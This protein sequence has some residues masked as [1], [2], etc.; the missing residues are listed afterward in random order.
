[1]IKN[2]TLIILVLS[3]LISNAQKKDKV[4]LTIENEPIYSSEFLRIYNKNKDIVSAENKKNITEYLELFINYKLK[5]REARDLKLD[6][7]PSYLKEF[8]KY[9]EQ[10]IE[11]FLKDRKVTDQLIHEAY[12]R[13]TKEVRASHILVMLKPNS[14]PKDTLKAYTKITEARKKILNGQKFE[15]VALQTSEDPSVKN[16]NGDLGYFSAFAMVYPFENAAYNTAIGDISQPFRTK[17]GYHIVKTVD[18]RDSKGEVQ[19]AHIMVRDKKN[20]PEFSKK[21]IL[22]IY[23]KIKQGENFELLAKKNSDDKTTA[24]KGGKL[25]AFTQSKMIQP[26]ADISFSL[27]NIGDISEP[28]QT[29]FGWHIV[30][31]LKKIPVKSFKA[32]LN[33]LTKKVEKGDRSILI[34]KSITDELKQKY[35]YTFNEDAYKNAFPDKSKKNKIIVNDDDVVL[36]IEKRQYTIADVKKYQQTHRDK[37]PSDFVDYQIIAYYKNHLEFEDQDFANTLQEYR[38]GLLLFDLLQKK[39]WTKAEKDTIGLQ[40]FFNKNSAKYI[41]KQRVEA[42]IASCSSKETATLVKQYLHKIE[43]T[44]EIKEKIN[45]DKTVRVLF[46]TGVFEIDSNKLPNKFN[47]VKG[48]E[49]YQEDDSHFTV[50]RVTRVLEATPKKLIEVKGKVISD[51]QNYLEKQWISD[52]RNK[53]AIT[54]HKKVLKKLI[55][56]NK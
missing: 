14:S 48:V 32:S 17:F 40:A 41:W 27:Q 55:R 22:D 3:S 42:D 11:P 29:K 46:Q 31:L 16:N 52:L 23:T 6:T 7:V 35:S 26:F 30:K 13:M 39:I 56:K 50:V 28:F 9:K 2:I 53:Y 51:Y 18:I 5:L 33:Y 20:D 8:N 38:D 10:L 19:V 24:A 21:Q 43:K 25:R 44:E 4:L 36:T 45:D 12:E 37:T 34:G 1:M 15:T 47:A 49:I 54:I